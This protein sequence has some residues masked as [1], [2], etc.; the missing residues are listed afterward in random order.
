MN[1]NKYLNSHSYKQKTH[2]HIHTQILFSYESHTKIFMTYMWYTYNKFIHY[3]IEL[4]Q[5]YIFI[6]THNYLFNK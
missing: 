6:S 4:F 5:L 3:V 1:K 2:I